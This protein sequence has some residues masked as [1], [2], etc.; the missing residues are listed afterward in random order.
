LLNIVWIFIRTY[1]PPINVLTLG[2]Y[3]VKLEWLTIPAV[4]IYFAYH[5]HWLMALAVAGIPLYAGLVAHISE[6]QAGLM[7]FHHPPISSICSTVPHI[8]PS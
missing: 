8:C 4:A 5:H 3:F 1:T 6:P 7:Y 2:V